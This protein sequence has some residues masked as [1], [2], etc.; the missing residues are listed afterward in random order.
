MDTLA[1]SSTAVTLIIYMLALVGIGIWASRRA[2]ASEDDFLLG[3]RSLGPVVAGLAYGASASSAWVL[4]G[5]TGF[6][7]SVGVAAVWMIPGVVV[8]Y[9]CVWFWLGPWLNRVA[10]EN[11]YLTALD[12]IAAD[13]KGSM[14]RA[15]KMTAAAM[16]LVS[17][18]SFIAVQFQG[19]GIALAGVF[20]LDLRL[21]IVAGALII[22]AYTFLGGFW[23][24]S[25]TD[26]LQGLSILLIAVILPLAAIIDAGGVS[27]VVEG[28]SA[29]PA[30]VTAPFGVYLGWSA[31]GFLFGLAALG[32]GSMGQPHLLTW[33]MAVRD[34]RA[35]LQGG[36]VAVG[37]AALVFSSMSVVGL[38]AR[39]AAEPGAALGE[40]IIFELAQDTLPGILPALLYAAILSAVMSTVDSQLLVA[41]AAGSHDLG[42]ARLAPGR[43]VLVT[44][45]IIVALCACAV[46][47]ALYLPASIFERAT[48]AW[49]ALGSAFGPIIV[50]RLLGRRLHP[51]AA[52]AAMIVAFVLTVSFSQFLDAGPGDWKERGLPWI[53][54]L[55]IVFGFSKK[56]SAGSSRI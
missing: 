46:L 23:A 25:I 11:G 12:V 48:F 7:A 51:G 2:S 26:T 33:V 47:V 13:T 22:F 29:Q 32:I 44:R 39:A 8:G 45:L 15:I 1:T 52:L 34:R 56:G 53:V 43:E 18:S 50:A 35:R 10:R 54:G 42:L 5:F 4:L 3:G 19:A 30:S 37:W 55:T 14:R 36:F 40:G 20:D 38:V 28:L 24:V 31:V 41:S 21:A 16:I 9:A 6:V 49:T 17:F 27:G